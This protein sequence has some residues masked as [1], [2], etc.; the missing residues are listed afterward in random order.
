[1]T[2]KEILP[3]DDSAM[4][5]LTEFAEL[6]K[7]DGVILRAVIENHTADKSGNDKK[8]FKGLFGDFTEIYFRTQDYCRKRERLPRNGEVCYVYSNE[9]KCDKR[10]HVESCVDEMGMAHLILSAYRQDT[11]RS[12][13]IRAA[14]A[15]VLNDLY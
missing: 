15:G 6:V 7:I 11:L 13:E 3:D 14:R 4:L 2:F 8:N 5:D 12:E 10:F 9:W 1:M